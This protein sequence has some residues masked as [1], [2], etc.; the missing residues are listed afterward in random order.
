M[1]TI[2]FFGL[3][4]IVTIG[5]YCTSKANFNM[6]YIADKDERDLYDEIKEAS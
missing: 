3:K 6:D 2:V 4:R 5:R 1:T